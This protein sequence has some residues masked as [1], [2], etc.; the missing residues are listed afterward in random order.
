MTVG[1]RAGDGRRDPQRVSRL[2]GVAV[3]RRLS[4]HWVR[5]RAMRL[6]A[7]IALAGVAVVSG[8]GGDE[9]TQTVTVPATQGTPSTSAAPT[10][11]ASPS[12]ADDKRAADG[13]VLQL[14]DLPSGWTAKD[15]EDDSTTTTSKCA[16]VRDSRSQASAR[17]SSSDFQ[18]DNGEV[19]NTV[20]VYSD[21]GQARAAFSN[22]VSRDTRVCLGKE[23][24]DV[25]DENV[26]DDD[27]KIQDA[28]TSEL[29]ITPVGSESA[30]A[31]ITI[32]YKAILDSELN[33][34]LVFVRVGRA[35]SLV[36]AFDDGSTFDDDLRGELVGVAARRLD[37]QLALS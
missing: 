7:L 18:K 13:A 17:A 8:C 10:T 26:E 11:T 15:D 2:T 36:I 20:Y 31:R 21:E 16:A 24:R 27:A 29:N 9:N 19:S 4:W 25:I 3:N 12:A 23:F 6:R 22:L 37:K 1:A 34:D 5:L 14:S 33:A 35:V 28:S 30:A 32:P